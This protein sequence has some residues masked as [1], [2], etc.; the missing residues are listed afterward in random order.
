MRSPPRVTVGTPL[1]AILRAVIAGVLDS[2]E[3]LGSNLVRDICAVQFRPGV[4][5][6]AVSDHPVAELV[7]AAVV[8]A[9]K[10]PS[11]T[12]AP[13]RIRLTLR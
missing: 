1:D 7:M 6:S 13:P 9:S 4:V 10:T 12:G 11:N 8:Q 5:D 2:E 3:R